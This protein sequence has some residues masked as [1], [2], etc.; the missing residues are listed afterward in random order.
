MNSIK[1]RTLPLQLIETD[2]GVLL[3]RGNTILSVNG[4]GAK[5]AVPLVLSSLALPGSTQE[6]VIQ[7]FSGPDC[8]AVSQF[9]EKLI[10]NK[11]AV[12]ADTSDEHPTAQ[13]SH[14]D[15]FYWHFGESAS[16]VTDRLNRQRITIVGINHISLQLSSALIASGVENFEIVDDPILGNTR[17]RNDDGTYR[18]GVWTGSLLPKPLQN[19]KDQ[20]DS[21]SVNCLVATSDFGGLALLRDWNQFCVENKIFFLPVVLQ[22]QIGYVGPLVIP[23]ETACLECLIARQNS[24]KPDRQT[25]KSIEESAHEGQSVIGFHPSMASILGDLAAFELTKF[26]SGVLAGWN[27]GTVLEINLLST[28]MTPRKVLKV[29]RCSVCSPLITRTP[30]NPNKAFSLLPM[31]EQV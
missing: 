29:P 10:S 26:F 6:E 7:K 13:E 25:S 3:K 31:K 8:K 17:L 27:V 16:Q 20:T 14:L 18:H 15:V 28:R 21:A 24:H 11:L 19:W 12:P 22:D 2:D 30:T 9:L 23:G 1:L 4:Q 5:T